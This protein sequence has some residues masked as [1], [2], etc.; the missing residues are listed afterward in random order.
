VALILVAAAAEPAAAQ[1]LDVGAAYQYLRVSGSGETESFPVG[2]NVDV[3]IP[4]A[5]ALS[6]VGEVGWARRSE[7]Y[8]DLFTEKRTR[9][10]FGGGIRWTL[11]ASI[12]P[13]VQA[14]L[15]ALRASTTIEFQGDDIAD[16]TTT[17]FL[18]GT[19]G[20]VTLPVSGFDL[21]GAAGYRRIFSED[22][23][24]NGFR[25]LAGVRFGIGGA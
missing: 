13:W 20:G 24:I 23:G 5:G 9:L 12:R 10:N 11:G 17:D 4:L 18:V 19:D 2:L 21:F 3:S 25:V 7:S 1:R 6:A 14:I 22:A 15:G 8:E 16:D